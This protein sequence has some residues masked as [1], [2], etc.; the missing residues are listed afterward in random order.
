MD[1]RRLLIAALLSLAVL[2]G[3][4]LAFPPPEPT[5]RPATQQVVPESGGSAEEGA[6][7]AAPSRTPPATGETGSAPAATEATEPSVGETRSESE[8]SPE[9][10]P[11]GRPQPAREAVEAGSEE[12]IVV[13]ENGTRAVFSNRGAQLVSWELLEHEDA[14]GGPVDLVRR[15]QDG[16]YFFGL[17]DRDGEPSSFDDRLFVS[18]RERDDEG[19][20]TLEFR[21]SGDDGEVVKR[22]RFRRNGLLEV[23]FH[24]AGP[25][26]WGL[27]LGPG[28]RNPRVAELENRFSR[29]SGIYL[30]GEEE[31]E[32][33]G[34]QG[35]DAP[36]EVPGRDLRWFG[37]EDTYFLAVLI[38]DEAPDE[39]DFL[40][41]LVVPGEATNSFRRIEQ[42]PEGDDDELIRELELVV[43][44][45]GEEFRA[46]AYLGAKNYERLSALGHSLKQTVRLGIFG[47]LARPLMWALLW[48]HDHLLSNY[49]WAIVL[50]TLV[51]R[52][53][54]FP[55][56]HKSTVSMKKM[57]ALNPQ[58]QAIRQKYR[59]KLKDKK[60]RPNAEAQRKMNEEI[61]TLYRKEGVNPAGG[62]LPIL[63]QMPV[64]FAFYSLLQA[65][66]ELR[67]APWILW[68][69]DLS[70]PDPYYVLPIVMGATQFIQQRLTPSA[71]DPMQRRI[72]MLMPAFFT[73]LFLKFPSGLVLYWLTSNLW[74]IGQTAITNRLLNEQQSGSRAKKQ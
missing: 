13:E 44:P 12:T 36:I 39:V 14:E 30:H 49:G 53:V 68:I 21:Y 46:T 15:R 63:L 10:I 11:S 3:W 54:L 55:L 31:L 64:L 6:T 73:I 8:V 35:A 61:M 59:P 56:T 71:G 1:D 62:C 47:F 23:D 22:F 58:I 42:E 28:I 52:L 37:L 32:L 45:G 24:V 4:Q 48:I 66:V 33:I 40:P 9:A 70:A 20:E 65:V 41:N 74:T 7:D 25:E 5:P 60:G 57:Q 17:T 29:R 67:H 43:Y 16:P 34:S 19:L 26:G 69:Q 18:S 27:V 2:I 38:P 50:L 51:V 72:M